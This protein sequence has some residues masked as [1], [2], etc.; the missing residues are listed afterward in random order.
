[1]ASGQGGIVKGFQ[2]TLPHGERLEQN[3][4]EVAWYVKFQSTLPHGER[5]EGYWLIGVEH[6]FN[7]RSR[8]GSDIPFVFIFSK[9][10]CFN[11]RSRTG[12]DIKE[13][14]NFR[15]IPDVS[16]HAPARGA[17]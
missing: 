8:T 12:S 9:S 5:L 13:Q 6:G 10:A 4:S 11:P 17:T 16:I 7:P 15:Y 2:S 1:M 3:S 14:R